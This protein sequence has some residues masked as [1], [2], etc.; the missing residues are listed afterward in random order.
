MLAF[1]FSPPPDCRGVGGCIELSRQQRFE[2]LA[3][4]ARCRAAQSG[5]L[6]NRMRQRRQAERSVAA[7]AG[8]APVD[9]NSRAQ[10]HFARA[11]VRDAALCH[12]PAPRAE[13]ASHFRSRCVELAK[14]RCVAV[15]ACRSL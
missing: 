6:F 9:G 14:R 5:A 3:L 10:H 8:H 12:L 13:S 4:V 11:R 1:C 2:S 15:G 7:A